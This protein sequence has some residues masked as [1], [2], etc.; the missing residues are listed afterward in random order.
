MMKFTV[1][2]G[3]R[4]AWGRLPP[5]AATAVGARVPVAEFDV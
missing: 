3:W 5:A 2:N 4:F 1:R